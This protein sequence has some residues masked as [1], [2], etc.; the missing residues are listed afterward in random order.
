MVSSLLARIAGKQ[1]TKSVIKKAIIQAP[2]LGNLLPTAGLIKGSHAAGT[3][4]GN[5]AAKGIKSEAGKR[6]A[7]SAGY[8]AGSV[9]TDAAVFGGAKVASE[10][11]ESYLGNKEFDIQDAMKQGAERAVEIAKYSALAH[12]PF[13]GVRV[14]KEATQ[15]VGKNTVG[16]AAKRIAETEKFQNIREKGVR[17]TSDYLR[18]KFFNL[19][20][21]FKAHDEVLNIG[22]KNKEGLKRNLTDDDWQVFYDRLPDKTKQ[23][24]GKNPKVQKIKEDIFEDLLSKREID[25]SDIFYLFGRYTK[26]LSDGKRPWTQKEMAVF[27]DKSKRKQGESL[28]S[29]RN[30]LWEI[31]EKEIGRIDELK[32]KVRKELGEKVP[33]DPQGQI[34]SKGLVEVVAGDNKTLRNEVSKYIGISNDA[35][36]NSFIKNHIDLSAKEILTDPNSAKMLKS[37][38]K[39]AVA[40]FKKNIDNK[41]INKFA[42]DIQLEN[43][44]LVKNVE[45]QLKGIGL[46]TEQSARILKDVR[47]ATKENKDL[48]NLLID[49]EKYSHTMTKKNMSYADL[50]YLNDLKKRYSEGA[51][52]LDGFIEKTVVRGGK[53]EKVI[54]NYREDVFKKI[55]ERIDS[56]TD[57]RL[58][59]EKDQLKS[60]TDRLKRNISDIKRATTSQP[61]IANINKIEDILKNKKNLSVFDLQDIKKSFDEMALFDKTKGLREY[62][63]KARQLSRFI[64]DL[65]N[66][67]FYKISKIKGVE[68]D[69]KE[70]LKNKRNYALMSD[71]QPYVDTMEKAG[72]LNARDF[73]LI[74]GGYVT[75][76]P[77]AAA[78]IGAYGYVQ[79]GKFGFLQSAD[80]IDNLNRSFKNSKNTMGVFQN[81]K[82]TINYLKS[83]KLGSKALN[84]SQI[85]KMLFLRNKTDNLESFANEIERSSQDHS[86]YE[87]FSSSN[88][89]VIDK[90]L[91]PQGNL[92]YAKSI[93]ESIAVIKEKIPQGTINPITKKRT[94]SKLDEINFKR[95]ISIF[96]NPTEVLD[97]FK[98][99]TLNQEDLRLFQ[100]FYP[101]FYQD[102]ISNTLDA[103]QSE[104]VKLTPGM[105]SSYN[106]MMGF[107]I[108]GN[109]N[110]I[111]SDNQLKKEEQLKQIRQ[112]GIKFKTVGQNARTEGQRL[113]NL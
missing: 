82:K 12:S 75:G 6:I 2:K 53:Q 83:K 28:Q 74:F 100:S 106:T 32:V 111:D 14:V 7:K 46:S 66:G 16:R 30:K 107:D 103:V 99:G 80:L 35:E 73:V 56:F 93:G 57:K 60:T 54:N 91:G 104:K 48:I 40:L 17:I 25:P 1:A 78:A 84:F 92:Q 10:G 79:S 86:Y 9:G 71:M 65:E 31:Q 59:I 87:D 13:L 113:S 70:L 112:G 39:T 38:L 61:V 97:R 19:K 20:G 76:G 77:L 85:G 47:Q 108:S 3:G 49:V 94:F 110:K 26:G 41:S 89:G 98:N 34:F 52:K 68:L 95:D 88:Y 50:N 22:K 101:K 21:Q 18:S 33:Q 37:K 72:L 102:F 51:P 36:I 42:D 5:L 62:N 8:L 105:I 90:Y 63:V 44:V 96:L 27:L 24:Y 11:L 55:D 29:V 64:S 69:A 109:I 4:L 43:S 23:L 45:K 15:F 58:F 81:Q 67:I